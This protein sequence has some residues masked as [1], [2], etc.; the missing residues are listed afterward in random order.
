MVGPTAPLVPF[1]GRGRHVDLTPPIIGEASNRGSYPRC[2][3]GE[4]NPIRWII[5]SAEPDYS[6][7]SVM[8]P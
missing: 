3:M 2:Q 1:W 7:G 8:P 5:T 6:G 4:A